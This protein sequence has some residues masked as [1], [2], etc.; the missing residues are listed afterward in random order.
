MRLFND[1]ILV[2][3]YMEAD[4]DRLSCGIKAD[5]WHISGDLEDVAFEHTLILN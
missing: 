2:H 5:F 1:E 3:C 4:S